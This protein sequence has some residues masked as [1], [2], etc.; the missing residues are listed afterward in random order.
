MPVSEQFERTVLQ[1]GKEKVERLLSN[2]VAVFGIGGVGGHCAE[3]LVRTGIGAIDVFDAGRVTLSN[4]NRQ[5]IATRS[6][7]GQYKAD[8]MRERLLDINPDAA[9]GA[10]TMFYGPDN[11]D[12]VDVSV[13]HYIIDA[14]DTVTAKLELVCRAKA[15]GVPIICSMGAATKWTPPLLRWRIFPKRRFARWRG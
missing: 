5:I 2:R 8:V 10:Y 15:A 4:L 1:I 12:E 6:T 13:Y 3:A 7:V 11:A 9:V 14:V